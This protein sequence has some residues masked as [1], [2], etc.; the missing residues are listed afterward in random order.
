[1]VY[2]IYQKLTDIE[3]TVSLPKRADRV[4]YARLTANIWKLMKSLELKEEDR[5]LFHRSLKRALNRTH[6]TNAD[7]AVFDR[8]CKQVR[9]YIQNRTQ[10]VTKNGCHR[11][12]K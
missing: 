10:P 9:W 8:F 5:G 1:V 3:K 2:E 7:I 11:E 4:K 12:E 6:W